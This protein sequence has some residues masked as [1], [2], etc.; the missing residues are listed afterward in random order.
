MSSIFKKD[1]EFQITDDSGFMAIVNSEKYVSFVD[2]NWELPQLLDH[3]IEEMNKDALIIWSTG[4]EGE[5]NVRFSDKPY[6]EKSFREFSKTINITN[7]QLFLANYEDLTMAAQFADDKIP[8][9]HNSN[10]SVK[11][12]NG[13]YELT[14]RQMFDPEDHDYDPEGKI[15]FEVIVKSATTPSLQK[16]DSVYWWT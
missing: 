9:E 11:L 13:K 2:E 4:I 8:A 6:S 5:W 16:I 10:L 3:F 12:P 1:L 7:G 15:N 14:I